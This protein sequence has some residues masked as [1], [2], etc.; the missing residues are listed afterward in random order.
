M[1]IGDVFGLVGKEE[2]LLLATTT[3]MLMSL[4]EVLI[5]IFI[6][7]LMTRVTILCGEEV[8]QLLRGC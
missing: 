4:I 8:L 6:L 2:L 7:M 1:L 5:L 3:K